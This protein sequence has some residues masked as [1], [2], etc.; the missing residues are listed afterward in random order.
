MTATG[1]ISKHRC[2]GILPAVCVPPL[3]LIGLVIAARAQAAQPVGGQASA[4]Y[5]IS[6]DVNL[7]ELRASVRDR[8][9]QFVPDLH[10]EDFAVYEDGVRQTLRLFQ[11][12]DIPVA[13][14]L[15]VDHSGSMRPKLAQVIAAARIFV[16][17]S[18][19]E[20]EMFVVNFNEH[21]TLGLGDALRFSN[22]PDELAQA[23]LKTPADGMTALY[24]AVAKARDGLKAATRDKK[25]LIVISDGADNA[26]K[27]SLAQILKMAEQSK[28]LVY[29]V[30]IFEEGD[31]DRNPDVLRRLALPTGGEAFFPPDLNAVVAVCEGIARDIRH[32]YTLGYVS[33]NPPQPGVFHNIS[34][35]ARTAGRGKLVVR[36]RPG[37]VS[38]DPMRPPKEEAAK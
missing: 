29:T 3:L 23:I 9:G 33:S 19:P 8:R 6:V 2:F 36:T 38:A 17:A 14:G 13:V 21:V 18:S 28:T 30:G 31:P 15:V 25:V 20:D 4:P 27:H 26:S 12:E 22:S 35:V 32:Q 5:R 34:V 7:V 37:Y 24:D 11:H 1:R 10:E 16:K